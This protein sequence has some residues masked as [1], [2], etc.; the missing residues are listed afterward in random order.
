MMK[1]TFAKNGDDRMINEF[2]R[3]MEFAEEETE[4]RSGFL[5]PILHKKL[6]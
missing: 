6:K 5:V 3:I 2:K 1:R 4:N